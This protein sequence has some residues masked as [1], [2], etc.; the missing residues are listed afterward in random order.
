MNTGKLQLSFVFL[1]LM[2][3]IQLL[4]SLFIVRHVW[5]TLTSLMTMG[6]CIGAIV[7]MISG[8]F[9]HK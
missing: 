6:L 7:W 9:K 1:F 3:A 5:L 2:A 4:A 8:N